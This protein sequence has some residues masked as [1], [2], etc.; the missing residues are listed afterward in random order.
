M[1]DENIKETISKIVQDCLNDMQIKKNKNRLKTI[2]KL[3][4][5]KR[6]K[7]K[8]QTLQNQ[9]LGVHS[10][11][12]NYVKSSVHKTLVDKIHKKDIAYTEMLRSYQETLHL[13]THFVPFPEYLILME[14]Y[15]ENKPI[16]EIRK[17][18]KLKRKD[19]DEWINNAIDHIT[20]N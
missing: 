13:I 15:I 18:Y 19:F 3:E 5:Y 7:E 2:Y 10:I 6:S 17:K 9:I 11:D 4:Q 12:Y 14:L 16:D 8:Y 1:L 20:I